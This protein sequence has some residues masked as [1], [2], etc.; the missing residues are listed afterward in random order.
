MTLQ[1]LRQRKTGTY[2]RAPAGVEEEVCSVGRCGRLI[3][4][5]P[6]AQGHAHNGRHVSLS[7]KHVDGDRSAESGKRVTRFFVCICL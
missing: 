6:M 7:A 4:D 2:R 5:G 3:G 1:A